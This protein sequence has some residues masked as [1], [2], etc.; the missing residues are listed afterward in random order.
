MEEEGEVVEE[1]EVMVVVFYI[2]GEQWNLQ[3]SHFWKSLQNYF[4]SCFKFSSKFYVS[5]MFCGGELKWFKG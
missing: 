2:K 4:G 3:F 1:A 5:K